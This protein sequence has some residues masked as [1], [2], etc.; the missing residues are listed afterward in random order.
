MSGCVITVTSHLFPSF[1]SCCLFVVSFFF[2]SFLL[3]LTSS[4]V[5]SVPLS[6]PLLSVSQDADESPSLTL[7][8]SDAEIMRTGYINLID[9]MRFG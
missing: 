5:L 8:I 1:F 6:I 3:F 9:L 4:L 2:L 7:C